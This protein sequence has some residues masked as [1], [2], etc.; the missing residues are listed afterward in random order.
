MYVAFNVRELLSLR[1]NN[2]SSKKHENRESG[3]SL[4]MNVKDIYI[5]NT[6]NNLTNQQSCKILNIDYP[7]IDSS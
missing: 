2:Y 4:V 5:D 7:K 1:K 6:R 3:R